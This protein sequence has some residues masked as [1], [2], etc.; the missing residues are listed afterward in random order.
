MSSALLEKIY[1]AL[2][3]ALQ[4]AACSLEGWRI[5]RLRYSKEFFDLLSEYEQRANYSMAKMEEFRD[6][7]VRAI[8][9]HCAKSVPYYR[10]LFQDHGFRVDRCDG[11]KDLDQLPVLTKAVVQQRNTE[12]VSE[13]ID[14]RDCESIHT[15]GTTGAGL[16]FI[17]TKRAIREAW[18]VWWRY[19]RW[20]QIDL[21]TW[22]GYF[23]GRTLVP[24][25]RQHPPFWR[26]NAPGRQVMF[27]GYHLSAA[28][29]PAYVDELNRRQL[30]WIHG[31]PSTISV[32]AGY[33]LD[34][35]RRLDYPLQW[36]T[37]GAE[38][39][40]PQQS[41]VIEQAFG[42]RPIQH[43]GMAEGVANIS[44]QLDGKLYVDEDYAAV[45]FLPNEADGYNVVGTNLTNYAFPLLRYKVGDVVQLPENLDLQPRLF[46]GRRVTA[47]DGRQE[48]YVILKNGARVGRMDHIFKDMTTI[49]EAQILQMQP[50]TL[51]V[52]VVRGGGYTEQDERQLRKEF[53]DRLGDLAEMQIQYV[54]RLEKSATGKLRFV[55][56]TVEQGQLNAPSR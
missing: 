43:Y 19:R 5:A 21:G 44:E 42:V 39:L 36:I 25:N 22:C 13:E 23:G 41:H 56:S 48:D 31:Y 24:P 20:H 12:F 4:N 2:P 32:L 14:R 49:R 16:K 52:R 8:V 38:N 29:W 1:A 50:G 40:L 3:V 53:S 33:L 6:A 30:R 51:V 26:V 18:A 37:I 55:V 45:E 9:Q 7:R 10:R 35:G 54:D 27:S 17:A 47:I 15:S 34:S 28:T 11:L 46:P